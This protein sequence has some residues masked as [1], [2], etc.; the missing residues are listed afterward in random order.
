[1]NA[2]VFLLTRTF[3]NAL[4][5]RVRRLRDFRYLISTVVFVAYFGLVCGGGLLTSVFSDTPRGAS[6]ETHVSATGAAFVLGLMILSAT[7][8][9][10]W[11]ER[12]QL[13]FSPAEI[14][15]LFPAPL[16]RVALVRLKIV[17][18][19]FPLL[20]AALFATWASRRTAGTHWWFVLVGMWL[21]FNASFLHRLGAALTLVPDGSGLRHR[22]PL[23][24]GRALVGTLLISLVVSF[25]P[26]ER[27]DP[28]GVEEALFEWSQRA[29]A[30]WAIL[31]FRLILRPA[32]APDLATFLGA[33][34]GSV[35][36]VLGLYVW[37]VRR[38][39]AFE[40]AAVASSQTFYRKVQAWRRA[41]RFVA[42]R[43]KAD[44]APF[45]L[46]WS[47]R[48]VPA[49][50]WKNFLVYTR[51]PLWRIVLFGGA[52]ALAVAAFAR[53]GEGPLD[54]NLGEAGAVA[55]PCVALL[56]SLAAVLMFLGPDMYRFDLRTTLGTPDLLKALPVRGRTLFLGEILAPVLV[57]LAMQAYL[58]LLAVLLLS[59]LPDLAV[60]PGTLPAAWLAGVLVLGPFTLLLFVV[61]NG[62]AVCFPA[63][64]PVGAG[65]ERTGAEAG[66][67]RLLVAFVRALV[68]A[69]GFGP[70]AV[71]GG[72][73]AAVGWLALG[74]FAPLALPLGATAAA[75]IVVV[76]ALVLVH[77]LGGVLD[78]FD[79]VADLR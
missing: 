71:V 70:A 7:S 26:L 10:V 76:E 63:W 51:V 36:L 62:A 52:L 12:N 47:G 30:S 19:Q 38:D 3:W 78:R 61:A 49:L 77:V 68:L 31:P 67:M 58:L 32:L 48:V 20:V 4:K 27:T 18:A 25:R 53:W 14:Q 44:P 57:V 9:W 75:A 6:N 69:L 21:A 2:L 11:P 42:T 43:E 16:S 73:V 24:L 74:N 23:F 66:G 55:Y 17:K 5:K 41:G 56:A 8:T 39:A 79:P 1:M 65:A 64:V 60:P 28:T 59:G 54:R 40:E 15:F 72:T 45:A 33:L 34:P 46:A 22:L 35:A 50:V 37:V 29:P 13:I